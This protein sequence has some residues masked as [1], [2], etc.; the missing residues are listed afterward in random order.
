MSLF[1]LRSDPPALAARPAG[2]PAGSVALDRGARIGSGADWRT[3]VAIAVLAAVGLAA[4]NG[5]VLV[6]GDAVWHLLWGRELLD[7]TLTSFALGPTPHPSLL[8]LGAATSLLGEDASYTV[9]YALF[10]PAAFGVLL[11]A[12]FDVARRLS[13][14]WAAAAAVL[15]LATSPQV[16]AI[17]GAARYDIAFAALVMTA[18]ALEMARPRRGVAPL[19]CLAAAGLIRPEAWVLGGL[20]WLWTAP[21]SSRPALAKTAALAALAPVLWCAM[22]LLVMGDPLYS[23]HFTDAASATLYGQYSAWDNLEVAGRNLVWYLGLLPLLLPAGALVLLARDRSRAALPLLAT[24]AVSLGIFLVLVARGMA[25]SNR[26][27]LVPVCALAILAAVTIDGGGRR[28][29]RRVIL[30]TFL[31]VLLCVQLAGRADV[32]GALRTDTAVS[33]ERYENVRALVGMPGVRQ[34][35]RNCP[36]VSVPAGTLRPWFSLYSGRAPEAFVADPKGHTRPDL[37]L[38]PGRPGVAQAVLT[39][40]RF[41][42]DAS[43]AFPPGL[44]AGPRN[45][46]WAL[47]VSP[48]SRCTRGLL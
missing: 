21:G 23:L 3:L 30:G 33:H 38:A 24:L 16:L 25:S 40:A 48:A 11:A 15:I 20:Y 7:G 10:G 13:S 29:A 43:F 14:R 12:V 41:D 37:Y 46:D 18:V 8:V 32:Y 47:Y 6:N 45:A 22:D 28:T 34:A 17:A 5:A 39:R 36:Q 2:R 19:V 9:T 27:L 1:E 35:L 31:A 42:R 44:K 4:V 26:Y